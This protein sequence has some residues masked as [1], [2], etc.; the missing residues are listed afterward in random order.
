[1]RSWP[2]I[3]F[4]ISNIACSSC[5]ASSVFGPCPPVEAVIPSLAFRWCGRGC[6]RSGSRE[7]EHE[8]KASLANLGLGSQPAVSVSSVDFVR[9]LVVE[10]EVDLAQA[11]ATG[12]RREGY[13]VD[14]AND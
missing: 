10:D 11:I 2:T 14:V 6:G 12:L 4:L 3:T 13:A 1:T 7:V 8:R 5:A 9:V